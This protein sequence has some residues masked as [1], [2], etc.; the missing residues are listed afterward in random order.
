MC[1]CVLRVGVVRHYIVQCNEKNCKINPSW[2]F[3]Y[4]SYNIRCCYSGT[5]TRFIIYNFPHEC[6]STFGTLSNANRISCGAPLV[7]WLWLDVAWA[8]S[9]RHEN[10]SSRCLSIFTTIAIVWVALVML[11]LCACMQ[12][13]G[14]PHTYII[15]TSR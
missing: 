11:Q 5:F 12:S 4:Y 8:R 7:V 13:S 14:I 1:A 6:I 15:P 10:S 2:L 9:W 3:V